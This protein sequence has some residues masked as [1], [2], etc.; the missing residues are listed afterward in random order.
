MEEH[1]KLM[2]FLEEYLKDDALAFAY[3]FINYCHLIDDIIDEKISRDNPETIIAAFE[4][5]LAV[6]SNPFYRQ[7]ANH[8]F[9]IIKMV[10]NAYADSV[11]F[12]NAPNEWNVKY[13]A[14][15]A[16]QLNDVTLACI[17]ICHGVS[18]RR[19]ASLAIREL[20]YNAHKDS[21]I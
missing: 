15:L 18:Q 17:E 16:Q 11:V 19:Y 21:F 1:T 3:N 5:A 4:A 7:H 6:Y 13:K 14:V 10:T 2:K 20:S 9:P 12:Q 8:L